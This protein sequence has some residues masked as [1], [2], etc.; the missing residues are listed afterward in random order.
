MEKG[1]RI[2]HALPRDAQPRL[3]DLSLSPSPKEG[4][5]FIC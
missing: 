4:G 3:P 5:K 1:T 2:S